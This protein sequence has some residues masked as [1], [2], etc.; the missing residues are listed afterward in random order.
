MT[1]ITKTADLPVK[2][3]EMMLALEENKTGI[4]AKGGQYH[5]YNRAVVG[6][7]FSSITL[8]QGR[9]FK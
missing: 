8:P 2:N 7:G 4:C 1:L 6:N 3:N 9:R 5:E